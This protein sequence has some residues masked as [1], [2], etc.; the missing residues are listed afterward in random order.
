[1]AEKQQRKQLASERK[2]RRQKIFNRSLLV[3]AMIVIVV[4]TVVAL[5]RPQVVTLPPYLN[6]CIPLQGPWVYKSVFHLY[7]LINGASVSIPADIGVTGSAP[8]VRPIYTLTNNA[9]VH[10]EPDQN[11]TFTLGDF[12]LVWGSTY[13]PDYAKFDQNQLF[14]YQAD[15]YHHINLYVNNA[16][17][18]D[19]QNFRLPTNA[20]TTA[21][22]Y[23]NVTITYG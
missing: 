11:R 17:N 21:T 1:L 5:N 19:Y 23:F 20:T 18:T 10:V 2:A 16:T 22:S 14:N 12:F 6:R 3:G 13:G 15:S 4:I 8:C 9:A 7:I